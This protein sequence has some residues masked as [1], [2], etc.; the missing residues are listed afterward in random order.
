[1]CSMC[2]RNSAIILFDV[3][4]RTRRCNHAE[5]LATHLLSNARETDRILLMKLK[6]ALCMLAVIPAAR[7]DVVTCNAGAASV[8]VFDPS[9]TSGAVGDYTLDCTGG[10]PVLPPLPVPQINV[11]AFMNVP[12]LNTGGWILTDGVNMTSGI[13]VSGNLVEF[14]GV[15]FNPPGTGHVVL[16]VENMLVNPSFV[17]AG[18]EFREL[19]DI[20]GSTSTIV[21]NPD[22]LVA[23]NA[24]PEPVTSVWVGLG[25]GAVLWRLAAAREVATK[26]K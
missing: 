18:F 5:C 21:A 9:S 20:V 10:T 6:L 8:P 1:M 24:V 19:V 3:Q 7:S 26:K 23:V 2:S 22:Q 13:L 4:V 25:F 11:D 17:P 12:V 16:T 14:L 15:P